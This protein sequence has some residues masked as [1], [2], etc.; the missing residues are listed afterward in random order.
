[1]KILFIVKSFP[2][3]SETFIVNQIIYLIDQGHDVSILAE[4]NGKVLF[5]LK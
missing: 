4:K 2:K 1:M 3:V 5:I